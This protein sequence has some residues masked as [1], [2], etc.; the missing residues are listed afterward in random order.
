MLWSKLG[1]MAFEPASSA[2]SGRSAWDRDGTEMSVTRRRIRGELTWVI[3]RRFRGPSGVER[4]RRAAQ[5]QLRRAAEAEE[6][7]LIEYW[8]QHG[9]ILPLLQRAIPVRLTSEN[10]P[11]DPRGALW[12]DAIAY[13]R[14]HALPRLKP[15]TRKGYEALLTGP[16]LRHWQN[17][18]LESITYSSI[19]E[20]D[21]AL[22]NEGQQPSTR[23]N[24]HIL[25]RSVLRSVGPHGD[26]RGVYLAQLPTF[27]PLPK[28]GTAV[29]AVADPQD[30]VLLLG[31]RPKRSQ[32]KAWQAAQLVF[33]LAA[34]SGLR[35]SEVRALRVRDIDLERRSITV[36]LAR[37]NNEEAPPKSGHERRIPFIPV[38]LLR[39]LQR[40][41][42]TLAPDDHVCVN[43]WGKPWG[44]SG[45][46]QAFR[47]N[48]KRLGIEGS[49]YHSLRH[50]FATQL[51]RGTD[52]R[53]VQLLLGHHSL[54]VTQRYAHT[55][56]DRARVAGEVF[57]SGL[58]TDP[59][60][61]SSSYRTTSSAHPT[62]S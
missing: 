36:R 12:E 43:K 51:F 44:D 15:S 42:E 25:L 55:D 39:M 8:Q 13:Y 61:D 7:R 52:A 16:G 10:R 1:S 40:R 31:E 22:A 30:L 3:D 24:H 11:R 41:C 46:W 18:T 14:K 28:V 34:Y 47:R 56:E 49:R 50:Y 59:R 6:R 60:R 26:E 2:K 29:V 38:P 54:Q 19:I 5:V 58:D 48:C 20:W 37:C 33:A 35:A 4:Y 9:T 23:R 45:I 27:P 32:P 53:T 62:P 17:R 57:E 21:A